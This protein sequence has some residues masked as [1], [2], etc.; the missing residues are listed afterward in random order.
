[1]STSDGDLPA[2]ALPRSFTDNATFRGTDLSAWAR[3]L[4]RLVDMLCARWRL[5]RVDGRELYGNWNVVIPV[6]R[7]SVPYMLKI[8]G[9]GE[10]A[11]GEIASLRAWAGR[12]AVRLI[13]AEPARGAMLLERLDA[14]HSL[15]ELPLVSAAEIAG[16]LARRLAIP[17]PSGFPLLVDVASGLALVLP[18]Q[19]HRLANP[20]PR[21]QLEHA[22]DLARDLAGDPGSM[23]VHGDLH[24][25]NVLRAD[26]Q[27]WL[28][29][30]PKP[31]VGH[32]ERSVPELMWT[33]LDEAVDEAAV[34]SLFDTLV[35]AGR[36][37]RDRALAWTVV[38]A[39]SYWL[40]GLDAGL[41]EDPVRCQRLLEVLT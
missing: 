41:T 3:D 5:T 18:D 19:Q 7:D 2:I 6:T 40:W 34:R 9:P 21:G 10:D 12:G 35:R 25:G 30:D 24:Y 29:I 14:D 22:V 17:A 32:P 28:A 26:R 20:V 11:A 13:A 39:V 31:F 38:R 15:A 36:F 1:M 37:D 33:R 16:G 23:L 27:P 4:P 8:I